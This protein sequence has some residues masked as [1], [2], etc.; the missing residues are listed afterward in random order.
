MICY[1]EDIEAALR[2]PGFDGFQ[3][4]D[5]QDFP[6]QGTALVGILN[7]F[8]ESKGL[9]EPGRWRRFC[10]ETVPLALFDRYTWTRSETFEAR[11][12]AAHYGPET[13]RDVTPA[14]TLRGPDGRTLVTGRLP[15]T[16]VP[17]GRV[18]D[19]GRIRC[20][21]DSTPVPA[22]LSLEIALEGTPFS[23]AYD[24][25]CYPDRIAPDPGRVR[26]A[27]ALD[28]AAWDA[29]AAGDRVLLLPEPNA[30]PRAV[31]GQFAP[32][33]WNYGMFLKLAEQRNV[34]PSAGTLGL[35][36]DPNHPALASF[37]TEDHS[38][39]QWFD[40]A[41]HAKALV[42]DDVT[43]AVRPIVQVI[44]NFERCHRLGLLFEARV[45][46]GRLMVC[47]VDLPALQAKPEARQFLHSLLTYMNSDAFEPTLTLERSAL[48]GLFR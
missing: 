38:N 42:L 13:L 9:V 47:T 20:P 23:N 33:F 25:W 37:P 40:L 18:T 2:T 4:L 36:I 11:V 44:D 32:E 10:S 27:R 30:L 3:L 17:Q 26:V 12:R 14:W 7:A 21:L 48:E 8:M 24:L 19:L 45:G 41:L 5:L 6:G 46:P 1:R 22:R 15:R 35:L 34:P 29:L 16:D 28:R 43:P 31:D 39:W